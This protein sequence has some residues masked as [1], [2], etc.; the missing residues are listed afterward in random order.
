MPLKVYAK[1]FGNAGYIHN[2]NFSPGNDLNNRML[3]SGGV[4][5]DI[6]AF[7]DLILNVEWTYNQLGQNGLYLHQR[8][9]Y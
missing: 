4:G 5:L 6:V 8:E 1:A 2:P 3:Y 7:A 9:R